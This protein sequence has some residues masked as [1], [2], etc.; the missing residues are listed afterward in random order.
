MSER[1]LV[2]VVTHLMNP[3]VVYVLD[4]ERKVVKDTVL[5]PMSHNINEEIE[6]Y[7]KQYGTDLII[8]NDVAG[9]LDLNIDGSVV[10]NP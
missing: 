6:D 10:S 7:L 9:L 5:F 8:C 3:T 4:L 1:V 2:F